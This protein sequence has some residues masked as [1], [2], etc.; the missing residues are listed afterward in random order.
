[1]ASR[2][3][4]LI[5]LKQETLAYLSRIPKLTPLGTGYLNL[6]HLALVILGTTGGWQ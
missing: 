1:M 4:L 2:G 6:F 5:F 3:S